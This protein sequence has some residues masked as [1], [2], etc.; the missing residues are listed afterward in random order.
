MTRHETDIKT[1]VAHNI[2]VAIDASGLSGA[3]LARR[4]GL[5]EKTVR[6]WRSGE[7]MPDIERLAEVAAQVGSEDVLDFY[8]EPSKA[9]DAS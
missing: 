6:R 2:D 3:E 4:L 9:G 1:R 8:R 5:N 7:V